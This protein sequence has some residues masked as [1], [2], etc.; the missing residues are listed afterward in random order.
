MSDVR[1]V[2]ELLPWIAPISDGVVVCKDSGL[3][4][5]FEFTGADADSVGASE[6]FQAGQ[7]CERMLGLLRDLPVTLWWTVRRER[8][9]DYPGAPMPDAVSQLLD[10]EHRAQFLADSAYVN[11]HFLSVMWRP[12]KTA[13]GF[14]E[15][16]A[17]LMADGTGMVTAL[18][19]VA[20]AYTINRN[21]F[22]WAAVDFTRVLTDY[23]T[24]LAQIENVMSALSLRRLRGKEMLGLLWAQANPGRR[25]VPKAWD[26]ETMLDV[27]VPERTV[28][29]SRDAIAFGD[30][31]AATFASVISM[32]SWPGSIAFDAFGSLLALPSEM[33]VSHC[34]RVLPHIE[35]QK[36][37]D[38]VK[39]VNE[40]LK[41]PI[42]AWLFAAAKGGE[43]SERNMDPA[44]AE[45]ALDAVEAKGDLNS[46]RVLFGWHGFS[47]ALLDGDLDQLEITTTNA[48]R[49]F[50]GS[51]FIGAMR[52]GMHALA[53]WAT[54]L[55]GQWQEGRRWMTLSSANMTDLAPLLGVSAGD[56]MNDH[57]T[58]QMGAPAQ[59]MT[60][61]AT[62]MNT[63]YY[64][65][66]HA[67]A[68]GHALVVGPSRSGKSIG[69][70]FFMSQ[71]RKY[72]GARVII[73]D[74][75]YSCRAPT[76]LQGGEYIDLRPGANI[77]LNPL[78]LAADSAHWSFLVTWIEGLI[79]SRGYQ[80][81]AED[82][83]AIYE[84]V[85]SP[86]VVGHSNDDGVRRLFTVKTLLPGAL[87]V[88]LDEWV[89]DGQHAHVFDNVEDSFD[90]GDFAAIE[91]GEVMKEPRV[92]RA[93]MDYA[94]Y[95]IQRKLEAQRH[96]SVGVTLVYIEEAWFLL[97]DAHFAAR[98]KDWLKTFAKLNAFVV[99]CTQSIED[100]VDLPA[101]V[102]AA[103]RD[104]I[105]TKIFLPNPMAL[106]EELNATYRKQFDLSQALVE[107]IATAVPRQ[108][109]IIVKPDVARKVRLALT[110]IQVAVLRS[111]ISAQRVFERHYTPHRSEDWVWNYLNE[112]T[113]GLAS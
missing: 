86:S 92:A 91:M 100:L 87:G 30:D 107:R 32:K 35:A 26:G 60:V 78:L 12:E 38:S 37:I 98:L 96:G 88:H 58:E 85:T 101:S 31:D 76:L 63:P 65:N 44:R 94:F 23:E 40:L 9:D 42:K 68:L 61:L 73:F 22:A 50:H 81:T 51:P 48:L 28:E 55:P 41:Y 67:G 75:D 3:L 90:I 104:N 108:D 4:A 19:E 66:F 10:D 1:S 47:L 13:S 102:V 111:D 99:L 17:A 45:A 14:F 62:D 57:L 80:P 25:M 54:G 39:R 16:L 36:H 5:C 84:A 69:M 110:P 59:A 72:K 112:I 103:I 49:M 21:A 95:R 77:K 20:K 6:V 106:S 2:S 52:E 8:T 24:R 74:K 29:V 109:Y 79:A 27:F 34:Y 15:R 82:A 113:G 7:A 43:P 89:G 105:P 71:F 93:F 97:G 56:R 53:A 11:R 83:K 33:I 64:F 18:V 46:G 70:N